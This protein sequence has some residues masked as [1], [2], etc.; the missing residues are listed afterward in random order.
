MIRLSFIT[1]EATQDFGEAVEFARRHGLQGLEL[2][3][4]QDTPVDELDE[5]TLQQFRRVLD[6]AGLCVPELA[7]SFYK[8]DAADASAVKENLHKLERLCNAADILGCRMIRGFAFFAPP[9]GPLP[10]SE[11]VPFFHEPEKILRRRGKVL[12]LEADPSVNTSNHRAVAAL[13]KQL[14]SPCFGAI[15]DPGNDLY[16]P[17][18]ET[19]FPD[20]YEAVRP[21]LRHVHIKDAVYDEQGQPQC[22]RTGDGLVPYPALLRRLLED[23][24]DGWLSLETHYRK[25]AVLTEQQMRVPQGSAFSSG[26]MEAAAE[27]AEALR[28][29]LRQA[30]EEVRP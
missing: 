28:E 4:V 10:A 13:L 7:G 17:L 11:L 21:Y 6:E 20:G 22:V 19:P 1:D 23:G 8:C 24:Y 29:L 15:Y 27:S 16:D 30:R 3:S 25:N 2:R 9:A 5:A 26:G 14:D 18:R 12:L